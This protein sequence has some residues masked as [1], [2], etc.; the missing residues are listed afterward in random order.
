MCLLPA[1]KPG[2]NYVLFFTNG[3]EVM[4]DLSA[5]KTNYT[6]KWYEIRSGNLIS[7]NDLAGGTKTKVT[8]PGNLEWIAVLSA[9]P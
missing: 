9:K 4:L 7:S 5:Y 2:E 1:S 8:A 6:I 3:G